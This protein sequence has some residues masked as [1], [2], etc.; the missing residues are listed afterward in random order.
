MIKKIALH[1][2]FKSLVQGPDE[3]SELATSQNGVDEVVG[4]PVL[5]HDNDVFFGHQSGKDN[6]LR[7]SVSL[8]E[9]CLHLTCL[10]HHTTGEED[11][12]VE[13]GEHDFIG[14][15][16][17]ASYNHFHRHGR[18]IFGN[19]PDLRFDHFD[20]RVVVSCFC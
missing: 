3:R 12:S 6:H 14:F 4:E 1:R 20:Q 9:D 7:V 16:N 18:N 8:A 5:V 17:V 10:R 2:A 15:I 19:L 11:D 13:V